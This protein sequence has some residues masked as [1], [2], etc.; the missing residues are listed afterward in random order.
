M[1]LEFCFAALLAPILP[2]GAA[3]RFTPGFGSAVAPGGACQ[4][5]LSRRAR[6]LGA[7]IP[8]AAV[9]RLANRKRDAASRTAAHPTE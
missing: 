8:V 6:A 4:G 7:A 2:L 5:S 1:Y 9:A 3:V